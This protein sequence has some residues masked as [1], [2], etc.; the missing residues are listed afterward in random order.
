MEKMNC[1]QPPTPPTL[2]NHR[3]VFNR[4]VK[5]MVDPIETSCRNYFLRNY[6]PHLSYLCPRGKKI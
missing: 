5:V 3:P 4:I 1:A 6:L 2:V